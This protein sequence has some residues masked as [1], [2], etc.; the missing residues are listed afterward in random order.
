MKF[1]CI[2]QIPKVGRKMVQFPLFSF[3]LMDSAI[4]CTYVVLFFYNSLM[5]SCVRFKYR[6][7]Q[8]F[9]WALTVFFKWTVNK[10][11]EVEYV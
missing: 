4:S 7:E 2:V 3:G 11:L 10:A 9:Y 5:W 8:C 1:S 6:E